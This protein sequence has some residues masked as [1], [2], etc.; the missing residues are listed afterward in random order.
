MLTLAE[1]SLFSELCVCVRVVVTCCSCC[2]VEKPSPYTVLARLSAHWPNL[3]E[4]LVKVMLGVTVLLMMAWT[5][6]IQIIGNGRIYAL[7]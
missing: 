3:W 4:V 2:S 6:T 5:P 1:L 7:E